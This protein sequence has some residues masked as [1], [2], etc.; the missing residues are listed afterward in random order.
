MRFVFLSDLKS[1]IHRRRNLSFFYSLL[2]LRLLPQGA[3]ATVSAMTASISI[4]FFFSFGRLLPPS[5]QT[6]TL[7]KLAVSPPVFLLFCRHDPAIFL[8][9]PSSAVAQKCVTVIR[10]K[11]KGKGKKRAVVGNGVGGGGL[12]AR[13]LGVGR[14]SRLLLPLQ[15]TVMALGDQGGRDG[16]AKKGD[17]DG[18]SGT[19][20][21]RRS[22]SQT[23]RC[24]F[25]SFLIF[26]TKLSWREGEIVRRKWR[27]HTSSSL[28]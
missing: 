10:G 21:G 15:C 16:E 19:R 4:F 6:H 17:E 22:Q 14:C 18:L 7:T 11:R 27:L 1:R 8:P 3:A 25:L 24:R 5:A 20:R 23:H 12:L 9:F 26:E 2:L 13:F 28:G